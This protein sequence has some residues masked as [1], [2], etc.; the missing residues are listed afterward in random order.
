MQSG[1]NLL[2]GDRC[3]NFNLVTANAHISCLQIIRDFNL[4][5]IMLGG[6]GTNMAN[7]AKLWAYETAVLADA[8]VNGVT[9]TLP[10]DTEYR[11]Y[12]APEYKVWFD[13]VN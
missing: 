8:P 7:T 6:G 4:P 3:S 5:M 9:N 11:E 1:G 10:L 2:A 13:L 12:F